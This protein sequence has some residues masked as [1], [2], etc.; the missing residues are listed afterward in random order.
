MWATR[1]LK[2]TT[3]ISNPEGCSRLDRYSCVHA[4]T[5]P[6]YASCSSYSDVAED[7]DTKSD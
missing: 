6:A 5:Q 7:V 3:V 1:V 4:E 2:L